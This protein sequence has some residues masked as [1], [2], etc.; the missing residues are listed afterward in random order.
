[1]AKRIITTILAAVLLSTAALAQR[2]KVGLVLCGGGAKGAA[3][4]G[5]LKVLEENG[6]PIDYIAGTSM[7]S[8]V[9][10][11]YSVGYTAAQL[12]SIFM[13]QDWGTVMSGSASRKEISIEN[14]QIDDRVI[15]KIPFGLNFMA[16]LSKEDRPEG[17]D[18]FQLS[19]SYSNTGLPVSLINGQNVY[20]LLMG[21]TVGYHDYHDFND[22]PIPFACVA[23]DLVT[24]KEVVLRSGVLPRAIRAS[25]AIPAAFSPVKIDNMVL[26]DGGVK[27]NFPVDVVKEMGADIVIGVK[28]GAFEEEQ[29][30]MS[31]IVGM[32]GSM[33]DMV[34]EEKYEEAVANSDILI[35]PS[36]K[37]YGTLSFDTESLRTLIDNG[38]KAAREKIDEIQALKKRLDEADADAV[39]NFVGPQPKPKAIT[40]AVQ[41][42]D[43]LMLR[44]IE[45]RGIPER[46]CR[47]MMQ[48]SG[49]RVGQKFSGQDIEKA[50]SKMYAT[51][52]Y[53]SV[54]YTLSGT[55]SPYG[56]TIYCIPSRSNQLGIG[57][58]FD[59][60][61]I[62]SILFD[63]RLNHNSLYG[64]KFNISARLSYNFQAGLQYSYETP[65]FF[66]FNAGYKFRRSDLGIFEKTVKTDDLSFTQHQVEIS[67][68]SN[69][70]KRVKLNI[71]GHYDG[72]FYRSKLTTLEIP[73]I[74]NVSNDL[75]HFVSA[76]GNITV[77]TRDRGS[78]P[79][80]GSLL[81][82]SVDNYISLG[83]EKTNPFAAI[84]GEYS[85][86]VPMGKHVAF[87]PFVR[88]RALLGNQAPA[89]FM[90]CIGGYE[91]GRYLEHQMP[92]YGFVHP[93]TCNALVGLAGADLR[94]RLVGNHYIFLGGNY[95]ISSDKIGT[96][97]SDMSII[98]ARLG[99]AFNF[100]FGPLAANVHWSD[101]TKSVGAYLSV[102]YWF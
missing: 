7:G 50:I 71:G 55:E 86:V 64:S 65:A 26:V 8:I 53:S 17:P 85:L 88:A 12:D 48:R 101:M 43:S 14:K 46:E 36:V 52:A 13:I 92:F 49:L 78:F 38:E 33:L 60:E 25:M 76:Y 2:P 41:V 29:A 35:G 54:T 34:M 32:L 73:E 56:M 6:I 95:A 51:G 99:Y 61:E 94:L 4:V 58:R 97:L 21:Y 87:I 67:L 70:L 19:E 90:N 28:L 68:S 79:N 11:L 22:L 40:K 96:I 15:V 77:D 27:N 24:R 69:S 82:A 80:K 59:S 75:H 9:G 83:A 89:I 62:A 18:I 72:F 47:M 20:N 100:K 16:D 66:G 10:G 23:V 74:Y 102:G 37:G 81:K 57:M 39:N 31:N 44:S 91:E 42:K 93:R 63:A 45:I 1:M 30:D 5:V 98:G 84:E 3:H